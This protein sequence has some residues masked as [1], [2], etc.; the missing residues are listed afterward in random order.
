M[1]PVA[2][3][4]PD[5]WELLHVKSCDVTIL[6]FEPLSLT[7][8]SAGTFHWTIPLS[9]HICFINHWLPKPPILHWRTTEGILYFRGNLDKWTVGGIPY[10]R[11]I[12]KTSMVICHYISFVTVITGV[13]LVYEHEGSRRHWI[14]LHDQCH[15]CPMQG[16]WTTPMLGCGC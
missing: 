6:T 16:Q 15:E 4:T 7:L 2:H 13:W 11:V 14:P 12:L 3:L 8:G 5:T 10:F 1:T 9:N